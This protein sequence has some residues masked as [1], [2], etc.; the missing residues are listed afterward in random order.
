MWKRIKLIETI[1]DGFFIINIVFLILDKW[2]LNFV[3]PKD[4]VGYFFWLSLGLWLGFQWC[5]YEAKR[6]LNKRPPDIR[7]N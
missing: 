6:I 5:K 2:F 1:I 4:I 3:I 7:N